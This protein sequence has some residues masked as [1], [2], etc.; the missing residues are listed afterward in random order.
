MPEF[1]EA[2]VTDMLA[3]LLSQG[4]RECM[5]LEDDGPTSFGRVRI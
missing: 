3:E 4:Q 2:V 5:V 1:P